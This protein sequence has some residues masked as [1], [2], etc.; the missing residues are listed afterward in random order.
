MSTKR[1]KFSDLTSKQKRA[2]VQRINCRRGSPNTSDTEESS[3]ES[4]CHNDS[5]ITNELRPVVLNRG[6]DG[7]E[8]VSVRLD[9]QRQFEPNEN[10]PDVH[11]EIVINNVEGN[12]NEIVNPVL[13]LAVEGRR[14]LKNYCLDA[15]LNHVQQKKL[16][17]TLRNRPFYMH[18]LPNDSRTL[19]ST[20]SIVVRN[21]I[22]KTAGGEYLHLGFKHLLE[23]KLLSLPNNV[24]PEFLEVDISTDGGQL[25]RS[26]GLQF[27]PLQFR[28]VNIKVFKPMIAGVYV[29][30]KKPSNSF[31]LFE[32]LVAEFMEVF[33]NGGLRIR[34]RTIP[35]HIR[36][37][38]GD[39]PARSFVLN[40]KGHSSANPCSKCKVVGYRCT[41]P[42]FES[43]M[44]FP[45]VRHERRTDEEYRAMLDDDHHKGPSPLSPFIGLV[46][47]VPFEGMHLVYLGVLK[48]KL[49]AL[50]HGKF[51]QRRLNGRKVT[52]IDSRLHLL[53]DYCPSEFNRKLGP[54]SQFNQ[55]KATQYR[56][57]LLYGAP[58]VLRNILN[59]EQYA[60][61]MLLHSIIRFLSFEH[62]SPEVLDFCQVAVK[63]Y[64]SICED[65]YGQQFISYNIH[66]LLH[67]VDDVRELGPLDSFSA[68]CYENNMP[69]VRKLS[70]AR[71]RGALE[72][73][74]NRIKERSSLVDPGNDVEG[75]ITSG[76]HVQGPLFENFTAKNCEQFKTIRIGT[77]ILSK[78]LR[79]CC[80]MLRNSDICIIRNILRFDDNIVLLVNKFR[81]KSSIFNV[82][83]SSDA[84]GVYLCRQLSET[85]SKMPLREVRRKCYFMPK[86]S[87]VEGEEENVVQNQY[88]CV[89]FITP[90]EFPRL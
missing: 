1:K 49:E 10:V 48:R 30:K 40:H 51:G 20:P 74:H 88:V 75:I 81:D 14:V 87:S 62:Q 35:L 61:M 57:L 72:Q 76:K 13:N 31:D 12:E 70:T 90:V 8:E 50:L 68:F 47:R 39:A 84:V 16:L 27:W 28:V 63:T 22:L 36:C 73:L 23:N 2:R 4:T 45:G 46:S 54:L 15:G 7:A 42:G 69:S 24:L 85:L 80:C 37:F 43:T 78:S 29:G 83:Y 3:G 26:G 77:T 34:N 5:F 71:P 18:Y 6:N 44:V 38:I 79:D 89:T 19:Q 9:E 86:W 82:G 17:K 66:A 56:Q 53:E 52:I 55:Y 25:Y 64:V 33:D 58:A 60:N 11:E 59:E 32:Q 21:V 41:V 65:L 67:V